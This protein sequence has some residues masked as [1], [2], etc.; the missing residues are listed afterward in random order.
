AGR[1]VDGRSQGGGGGPWVGRPGQPPYD[2]EAAG[3]GRGHVGHRVGGDAPGHEPGPAAARGGV[4]DVLEA[5]PGPAGLGGRGRHR[6]CRPGDRRSALGG[7]D[8]PPATARTSSSRSPAASRTVA[9]SRRGTGSPLRSTTTHRPPRP[10][11]SSRS[12]TVAPSGTSTPSPLAV[13]FI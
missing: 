13:T 4:G 11:T 2:D 5:R 12:T 8:Q 9:R 6:P 7:R 3:A 10:S 1:V